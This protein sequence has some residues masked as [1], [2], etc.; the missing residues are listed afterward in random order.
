MEDALTLPSSGFATQ[1][2]ILALD[3]F[4][5]VITIW[6]AVRLRALPKDVPS[7]SLNEQS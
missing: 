1:F 7:T 2:I 3:A 5:M 4:G 6:C